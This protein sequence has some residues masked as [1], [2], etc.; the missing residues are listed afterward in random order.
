MPGNIHR[1]GHAPLADGLI[2][3]NGT[4]QS[5]SKSGKPPTFDNRICPL[6]PS[7][8]ALARLQTCL[9]GGR[10]DRPHPMEGKMATSYRYVMRGVHGRVRA[11]FNM[12]DEIHSAQAVVNITAGEIKPGPR[13]E[14]GNVDQDFIYQLGDADIW[15]SNVS[16]HFNSHFGGEP[17]GVEYILHVDWPDPLDVGITVTV[18]NETPRGIIN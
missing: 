8:T 7:F 3:T 1:R 15:V 2:V 11:N 18:E 10:A 14:I 13:S 4:N 12:P 17:G 6:P 9:A 5:E 16:P